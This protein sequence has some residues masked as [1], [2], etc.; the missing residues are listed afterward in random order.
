[1]GKGKRGRITPISPG[2][3]VKYLAVDEFGRPRGDFYSQNMFA[4]CPAG[5]AR[6]Q[7]RRL[8]CG[9]NCDER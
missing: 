8:Q 1:M 9:G 7:Q 5:K 6:E 3:V 4:K 2:I